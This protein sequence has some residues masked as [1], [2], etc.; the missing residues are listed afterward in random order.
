MNYLSR[1]ALGLIEIMGLV[2]AVEAADAA[3]KSANVK[4]IGYEL[5]KGGGLVTIKLEGEV[6]A[7]QAAV[8]AGCAAGAKVNKVL[9]SLVIPRPHEDL[10]IMTAS[11]ETIGVEKEEKSQSDSRELEMAG[12]EGEIELK[13]IEIDNEVND[14]AS[15]IVNFEDNE[16]KAHK[17]ATCNL[18]SDPACTRKK[19]EPRTLCIH[20]ENYKIIKGGIING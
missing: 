6:G 18:C 15:N 11:K 7:V 17:G 8:Q 14:E 9:C 20:C 3:V 2:A 16:K 10:G 4:L 1:L 12:T 19:G 13:K 5:A